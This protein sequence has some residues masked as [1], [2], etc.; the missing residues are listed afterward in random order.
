MT[1]ASLLRA[2]SNPFSSSY[3][4]PDCIYF[5]QHFL[6]SIRYALLSFPP[7]CVSSLTY[8]LLF[9]YYY[10]LRTSFYILSSF[11]PPLP[12]FLLFHTYYL[13]SFLPVTLY[14]LPSFILFYYFIHSFCSSSPPSYHFFCTNFRFSFLSLFSLLPF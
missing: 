7:A 1:L 10:S 11:L 12:Y 5:L 8:F 4:L 6:P 2:G 9:Y 13:N 3:F 14:V